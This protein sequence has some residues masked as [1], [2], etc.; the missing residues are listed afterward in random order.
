MVSTDDEYIAEIATRYGAKV[1]FIRSEQ[2]AD[3]NATTFEV[4]K[5]VLQKYKEL[6]QGFKYG[7]CIYPT[8]PFIKQ[9]YCKCIKETN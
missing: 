9:I 7:C 5:E 8:A 2:N 6:N 1:P 4:L 3:D